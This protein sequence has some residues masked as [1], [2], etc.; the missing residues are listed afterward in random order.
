MEK[1]DILQF[2]H[3][4]D[5]SCVVFCRSQANLILRV[6]KS[7]T[8]AQLLK[9]YD[10]EDEVYFVWADLEHDDEGEIAYCSV[11]ADENEDLPPIE[12]YDELKAGDAFIHDEK[13]YLVTQNDVG[14]I[15]IRGLEM[16]ANEDILR[17]MIAG[18]ND[19]ADI[20]GIYLSMFYE[21]G[22]GKHFVT[23]SW[24]VVFDDES[25]LY[26]PVLEQD[27]N[28]L[29]PDNVDDFLREPVKEGVPVKMHDFFYTPLKDEKGEWY[30][31]RDKNA[32]FVPSWSQ[33]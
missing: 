15:V 24:C 22:K 9:V 10:E 30:L 18:D 17:K 13:L 27:L 4:A 25:V 2:C 5:K 28:L 7:N 8:N 12:S 21:I 31:R 23:M 16:I 3:N 20:D 33:K 11:F 32:F 1:M 29:M 14:N 19:D 6:F 26:I